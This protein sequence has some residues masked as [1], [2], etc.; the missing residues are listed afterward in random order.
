MHIFNDGHRVYAG[1]NYPHPKVYAVFRSAGAV[2]DSCFVFAPGGRR[3]W[4]PTEQSPDAG[5]FVRGN[6]PLGAGK[7]LSEIAVE[8]KNI[9]ITLNETLHR[10]NQIAM[11]TDDQTRGVVEI[12]EAAQKLSAMSDKLIGLAH[13]LL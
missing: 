7:S 12:N 4:Q 11:A 3:T 10:I 9:Q 1:G 5:Q 2:Y 8:L 6:N 13:E